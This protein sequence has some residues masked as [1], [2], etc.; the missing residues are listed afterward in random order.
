MEKRGLIDLP[1]LIKN[2]MSRSGY[3]CKGALYNAIEEEV[4]RDI[5]KNVGESI[6]IKEEQVDEFFLPTHKKQIHV[7]I[8]IINKEFDFGDEWE[9]LKKF[10]LFQ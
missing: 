8:M 4:Y 5:T 2:A 1:M 6:M 10:A 3:A 7:L 9:D